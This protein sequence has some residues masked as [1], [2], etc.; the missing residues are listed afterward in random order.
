M[1]LRAIRE[2]VRAGLRQFNMVY[3]NSCESSLEFIILQTT[4]CQVLWKR[5][6]FFNI[7]VRGHGAAVYSVVMVRRTVMMLMS[8]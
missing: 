1:R 7:S 6:L 5:H 3:G 4:V 8:K 2:A